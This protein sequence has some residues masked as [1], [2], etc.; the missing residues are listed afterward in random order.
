MHPQHIVHAVKHGNLKEVWLSWARV[1]HAEYGNSR[2]SVPA[3]AW[4]G[5]HRPLAAVGA[6]CQR[7]D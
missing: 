2:E 1:P 5:T 7:A 4:V 3:W 6:L